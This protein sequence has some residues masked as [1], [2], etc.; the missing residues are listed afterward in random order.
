MTNGVLYSCMRNA[1]IFMLISFSCAS[2]MAGTIDP[3]VP[4]EKY[5]K[6]GVQH[7]C[8][9]HLF[10]KYREGDQEFSATAVAIK[11]NWIV[12]AAHVVK[13]SKELS[14]RVGSKDFKV[15]R[16]IVKKEFNKDRVGHDD[17][18]LGYCSDD[19]G[20]DF[21][22]D[23]YEGRDEQ[24]KIV[25]ICG[26]GMT[27]D[28]STGAVRWDGKKR[29]GSNIIQRTEKNCLV[30]SVSDKRTE[31]EFLSASGDSGGGLFLGNKLAGVISFVS[32][33]DG[34]TDSDY[35]DESAF[36]RISDYSGWINEEIKKDPSEEENGVILAD[37]P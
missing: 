9:V 25:S 7:K 27:G 28:F 19:L 20:L 37:M 12:T 34:K 21:Y 14:V 24:G 1:L 2:S 32:S 36:T 30:C 17:I 31:L 18:A 6:Y 29:A 10:G 33:D 35:G 4:D 11:P 8:V 23:L 13:G 26:Y 5:I 22:P 16:I 3:K 15:S